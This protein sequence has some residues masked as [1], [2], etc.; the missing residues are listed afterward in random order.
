MYNKLKGDVTSMKK[1][2]ETSWMHLFFFLLPI[3]DFVSFINPTMYVVSLGFKGI[4]VLYA[5]FYLLKNTKHKKIF[6]FL[7]I[8]LFLY[9]CYLLTIKL[10]VWLELSNVFTIFS[11]PILILFFATYQNKTFTKK[12]ITILFFF[13]LVLFLVCSLFGFALKTPLMNLFILLFSITFLYLIESNSYLLKTLFLILFVFLTFFVDAKLF[14]TSILV[15]LMHYLLMNLKKIWKVWKKEQ[16]KALLMVFTFC[17]ALAIYLPQMDLQEN[18][19][20]TFAE[21]NIYSFK[22]VFA[23]QN[24]DTLLKG[25]VSNLEIAQNAYKNSEG[26]EKVLGMGIDKLNATAIVEG[27]IFFIFYSIGIVGVLFY[28]FFFAYVLKI[29]HLKKNYAFSF[30]LMVVLAS[31]SSSL[32]NPYLIPFLSVLFLLSKND[33]GMMKK[34]ILMVSNMYPSNAYPHYGIFVKNTYDIL[35]E[36][37]SIDLV[38]MMK[39]FGK[40][41]KFLSYVKMCGISLLKATFENYDFIYVHFAS[42]TPAGVFIPVLF[43]KNTKFVINVHGNDIVADTNVDKNYLILSKLFLKRANIIIA[44]SKYFE[45]ILIKKYHLSK[46][47]IVVYPSGGVDLEKFKKINKQTALK[48]ANLD[49]KCKYFGFVARIEK[50]KG[51]DTYIKAIHELEKTKKYKNV[52]YLLIGSGSEE[53]KL[54]AFIQKY[55]L[56]K[57]IICKPLVS[58]EELVNIYNALEAFIYPTRMKSESLGLT[59]LEAMACEALVIGSN[60]Y[61]PSDYL[62]NNENAYTFHPTDYKALAT[63]MEKV[64][65]LKPTEKNKL[66]KNARKKCEEYSSEATKETLLQVF[67][68]N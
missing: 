3:I 17:L 13:Y 32:V 28:L 51:Y 2:K 66:I 29:S 6:A 12:S 16:L 23:Y 24:I 42:H 57:V 11:L 49:S 40:I 18:I 61:G 44:P 9:L 10:N 26:L 63:L 64:L 33:Q 46:N 47:K 52:R 36:E 54:N 50:D 31:L 39:T 22:D 5:L 38:V 4:L 65:N 27:D 34:D 67:K 37:H 62:V 59:G 68:N 15:V 55:K 25:R 56:E 21:T 53:E 7:G 43:S 8:Y 20:N 1:L 60:Q 19:K 48:N 35:R 45:K 30:F 14:Y 41:K 58:Q